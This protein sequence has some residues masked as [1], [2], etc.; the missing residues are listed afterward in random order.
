[1]F[2]RPR[3][4]IRFLSTHAFIVPGMIVADLGCGGGYITTLLAAAVGPTGRVWAID[5]QAEA[6]GETREL[7]EVLG[8][9]N[10]EAQQASLTRL[11]LRDHG[12]N[13]AYLSQVLFQNPKQIK[14]IIAEASRIIAPGGHLVVLEPSTKQRFRHGQ[15]VSR[16]AIVAA[17]SI[18]RLVLVA[19]RRFDDNY[20]LI[21][22][23][24]EQHP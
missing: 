5:V 14:S 8:Y 13:L 12:V 15:I 24:H 21:V 17:A 2:L 19:E 16:D 9:H 11:P 6:V 20:N 22:F 23:A 7:A 4:V 18:S 10:I 3:E 1:M